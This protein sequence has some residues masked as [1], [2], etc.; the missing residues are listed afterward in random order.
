MSNL[1]LGVK[2]DHRIVDPPATSFQFGTHFCLLTS[3]TEV[4]GATRPCVRF[5]ATSASPYKG[6]EEND[7]SGS[8]ATSR[9]SDCIQGNPKLP[10]RKSTPHSGNFRP[11][12]TFPWSQYNHNILAPIMSESTRNSKIKV[13]SNDGQEI[14]VDRKILMIRSVMRSKRSVHGRLTDPVI[15]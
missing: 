1:N 14:M 7:F 10:L 6:R 12:D 15:T 3:T 13:I 9:L 4:D 2:V 11:S 5:H 8:P